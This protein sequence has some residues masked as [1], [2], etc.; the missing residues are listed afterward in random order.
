LWGI[1]GLYIAVGAVALGIGALP[2]FRGKETQRLARSLGLALDAELE[3]RVRRRVAARRSGG[4]AGALTGLAGA[5]A[6][7][8]S[9]TFP[10]VGP[11]ASLV[12]VGGVF[13]GLAVGVAV[14]AAFHSVRVRDDRPR[15]ARA[16]V[17]TL[18]D[19]VSWIERWGA[20]L[21]VAL[22][23]T[24][25][26]VSLALSSLGLADFGRSPLLLL[27]GLTTLASL[28]A[29]A[30]F[31]LGGR[32]LIQKDQPSESSAGLAWNDALRSVTIRDMA[33]APL[34]LGVYGIAMVI[35][36]LSTAIMATDPGEG[37]RF[38]SM[39][40]ANVLFGAVFFGAL[41]VLLFVIAFKPQ[42]HFL[43][44]L[45]PELANEVAA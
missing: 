10:S 22:A 31:E 34:L 24:L 16:A 33:S 26:V 39:I 15:V 35:V 23:A 9:Q 5:A 3:T 14:V 43:R 20:R 12:L 1:V 30:L 44:R 40:A 32:R 6:L 29:L 18:N 4:V 19:Y 37:V 36:D 7:L 41:F 28:A 8:V 42:R 17:V 25:L 11:L 13:A 27:G 45:W 38:V 2:R 21:P